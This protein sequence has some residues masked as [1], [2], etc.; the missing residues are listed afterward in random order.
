MNKMFNNIKNNI[1]IFISSLLVI[2]GVI[3]E[4]IPNVM[5]NTSLKLFIYITSIIL[6]FIDMKLKNRKENLYA[7]CYK[8]III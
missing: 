5:I 1:L 3:I 7:A 6:V 2:F 4:L 8:F